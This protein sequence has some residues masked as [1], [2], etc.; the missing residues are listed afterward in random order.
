MSGSQTPT[1][2][3]TNR[4]YDKLKWIAQI[5][6]PAVGA[7][8]FGLSEIWGLPNGADVVGTITIVD[9]FLG[10]LLGLSAKQYSNSDARFDG[11]ID[12]ASSGDA[13]L[14]SL[15]LHSDPEDLT[16]KSEVLFKVNDD[17]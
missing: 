9:T 3:L 6:L 15:N 1:P 14:F 2:F 16:Q 5:L 12:V 11:E 10:V 17:S 4:L 8:Y 13:K 7:L